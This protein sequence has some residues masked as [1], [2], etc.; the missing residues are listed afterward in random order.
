MGDMGSG[1]GESQKVSHGLQTVNVRGY[2][3]A[4]ASCSLAVCADAAWPLV[5]L[6]TPHFS[7]PQCILSYSGCAPLCYFLYW[8]LVFLGFSYSGE[9]RF[10][11]RSLRWGGKCF[12]SS[13]HPCFRISLAGV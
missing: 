3:I 10:E 12:C 1:A 13:L 8:P 5:W 9:V 4:T 6:W 2:E 7:S 11:G